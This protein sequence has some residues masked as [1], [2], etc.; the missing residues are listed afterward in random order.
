MLL[1]HLIISS[2]E[3]AIAGCSDLHYP[4]LSLLSIAE[5]YKPYH[6]LSILALPVACR[7]PTNI[8]V[9]SICRC[10]QT[11]FSNDSR[12]K[13]ERAPEYSSQ[14]LYTRSVDVFLL[15]LPNSFQAS[16]YNHKTSATFG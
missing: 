13:S 15:C 3:P 2:T 6:I 11:A 12:L 4:S 5:T 16:G 14:L 9:D 1:Y 10:A 8:S 7:S